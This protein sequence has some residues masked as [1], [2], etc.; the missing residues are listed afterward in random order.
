MV[1][2]WYAFSSIGIDS[3]PIEAFQRTGDQRQ[4]IVIVTVGIGDE[5]VGHD[6]REEAGAVHM[7]VR[8]RREPGLKPSLGVILPVPV[9][10][11]EPLA[12]RAVLDDQGAQVREHDVYQPFLLLSPEV[13]TSGVS[14]A[15]TFERTPAYPGYVWIRDGSAVSP[16]ELGTI[17]GPAHCDWQEATFLSIGWPPGT[18]SMSSADARQYIRDP[19]GVVPPRNLLT[20]LT[21]DATLPTDARSIGYRLGAIEIH[22]SSTDQDEAAYVVGPDGAER[23]PRSDPMTL[24]Q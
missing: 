21:L 10:L 6:A 15:A 7:T 12:D 16:E 24:C 3:A 11:R 19:K 13:I 8:V 17:A 4:I 1:V 5:V 18:E 23:W 9:L 14:V 2:A 22:L 20:I